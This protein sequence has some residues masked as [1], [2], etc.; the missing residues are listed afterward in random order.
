MP[1]TTKERLNEGFSFFRQ[2]IRPYLQCSD[3][4]PLAEQIREIRQIA[5]LEESPVRTY[6]SRRL[7][8]NQS[9]GV[10]NYIPQRFVEHFIYDLNSR[11][12]RRGRP[13]RW[14]DGR[15]GFA[16]DKLA[17]EAVMREAELPTVPVR[18][19]SLPDRSWIDGEGNLVSFDH[20][21][22]TLSAALGGFFVK[23][24]YGYAGQGTGTPDSERTL[25]KV[26]RRRNL[27]VQPRFQQHPAMEALHPGSLNTVRICTFF[28]ETGIEMPCGVV[29]TGR[30]GN[31]N[32]NTSSGG[33]A[34]PL[35]VRDGVI[36]KGAHA[37][38][39]FEPRMESYETHPD[40]GQAIK[41]FHVP[42]WQSCLDLISRASEFVGPG[43]TLGWDL[44]IG[45]DGPFIL[46]INDRWDPVF[47]LAHFDL[48]ATRF[49]E[50][51]WRAMIREG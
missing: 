16:I 12:P 8:E 36:F 39:Q 19:A 49:G 50:A 41:G 2:E 4:K 31:I 18:F 51:A 45:P 22:S 25:G 35:D 15:I 28:D 33:I 14:E 26:L 40:S 42:H 11:F 17:F 44:A 24:R 9:R 32:D 43:I 3:R 6:L 13:G 38:A 34:A 29:R 20:V 46:E 23:K 47:M 27:V 10:E 37:Y 30:G 21:Y 1:T 48:R 7:Y 5:P